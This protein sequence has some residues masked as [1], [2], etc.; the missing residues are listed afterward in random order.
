MSLYTLAD[1]EKKSCQ[2]T[3]ETRTNALCHVTAGS[4]DETS[5]I[6]DEK[7]CGTSEKV[8]L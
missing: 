2:M 6:G 7:L 5:I 4:P 1:R 8:K 3:P